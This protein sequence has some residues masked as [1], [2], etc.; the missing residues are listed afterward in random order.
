MLNLLF[1]Y[2]IYY[3]LSL[4][5][6]KQYV[7]LQPG[8]LQYIFTK[9]AVV[10]VQVIALLLY[11]SKVGGSKQHL[12]ACLLKKQDLFLMRLMLGKF[13]CICTTEWDGTTRKQLILVTVVCAVALSPCPHT[14]PHQT[15]GMSSHS[16][17]HDSL[18]IYSLLMF[19]NTN[20]AHRNI[21]LITDKL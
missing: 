10:L 7:P 8:D 2:F 1:I 13:V 21:L 18:H 19:S 16:S 5:G 9:V 3:Q 20:L 15:P 6:L 14:G 11:V 17:L 12:H 4:C